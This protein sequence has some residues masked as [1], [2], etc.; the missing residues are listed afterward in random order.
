MDF[1]FTER[2]KKSY[3][4][5]S[6]DEQRTLHRKLSLMSKNPHHPSLR[7][8]KVQGVSDIFECSVTMAIRMTWQYDGESI[9]LRVIGT[10]DE[11][12]DN[13]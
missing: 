11:V 4:K 2:F 8:K 1:V 7:T 12:L 6:Q 10:H 5:L 13:P 3:K 9:I